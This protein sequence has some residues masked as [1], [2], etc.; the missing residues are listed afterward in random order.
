[1]RDRA[2]ELTVHGAVGRRQLSLVGDGAVVF[3]GD[4]AEVPGPGVVVVGQLDAQS[5]ELAQSKDS[6]KELEE[7]LRELRT[8][9]TQNE[10]QRIDLEK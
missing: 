5:E 6:G 2:T 7:S 8:D 4:G 9:L 3:H 1:M 10:G